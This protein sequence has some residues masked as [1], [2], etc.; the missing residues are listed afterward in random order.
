MRDEF[1]PIAKLEVDPVL[2]GIGS[3]PDSVVPITNEDPDIATYGEI[4]SPASVHIRLSAKCNLECTFCERESWRLGVKDEEEDMPLS[5]WKAILE[6]IVPKVEGVE[7][8]GLGEPTLSPLFPQ[9]CADVLALGKVLYFP[10]NGSTIGSKKILD[11]IGDNPRVS[12]SVDA[13]DEESYKSVRGGDWKK[14]NANIKKFRKAKPNAYLHSQ[15]TAGTY[16]IDGFPDFIRWAIKMGF[17]EVTF[18]FVQTHTVSR[19]EVSLR[20][21][22]DRTEKALSAAWEIAHDSPLNLIVERR[23]YSETAPNSIE[24]KSPKA[25]LKR[26]LDFVPLA[27]MTCPVSCITTSSISTCV[28]INTTEGSICTLIE[29]I[30]CGSCTTLIENISTNSSW[31]LGNDSYY[32]AYGTSSLSSIACVG[33]TILSSVVGADTILTTLICI[34]ETITTWETVSIL[35]GYM[36]NSGEGQFPTTSRGTTSISLLTTTTICDTIIQTVSCPSNTTIGSSTTDG[37]PGSYTVFQWNCE[38][39]CSYMTSIIYLGNGDSVVSAQLTAWCN[40][41]GTG[42]SESSPHIY[43]KPRTIRTNIKPRKFGMFKTESVE[44]QEK[45]VVFVPASVIVWADGDLTTCF[46]KHSI[47]NIVTGDWDEVLQSKRYQAFLHRRRDGKVQEEDLC[48]HCP[49]TF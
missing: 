48:W 43:E 26:Y 36:A 9:V 29:K 18:R 7:V 46:A 16:N 13:W 6:K 37:V 49:R 20:F 2:A 10:T 5:V 31:S 47:G 25:L 30:I 45:R 24:D 41:T 33:T 44:T 3:T 34:S 14:L 40:G 17:N 15:Y 28:P 8:C 35:F 32:S 11:A 38:G 12:V 19:E 42:L 1:N 23:S 39:T 22:K 4:L 27:D 21:A